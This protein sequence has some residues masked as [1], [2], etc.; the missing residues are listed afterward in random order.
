MKNTV[1][2]NDMRYIA[3]AELPWELLANQSILVTGANG[4]LPAYMIETLLYLNSTRGL[5]VKVIGLVR[6]MLR[7]NL[8]FQK[9]AHRTDF[10]LIEH[11]VSQPFVFESSLN[12]IVHAA[13]QASPKYY[14]SDPVGTLAANVLGTYY[15]LQLAKQHAV[16]DF[17]YFSS[18][19]VY[20]EVDSKH[21]PTIETAYGLVDPLNI[22]S[23]YA[24]SKR[25]AENMLVSFSHQ[26]NIPGKIVRPFHTYGPGL[27]LDDGRVFSDFIAD[28]VYSRD[29]QVL[30]DGRAVR[31]FCYLADAVVG[32]FTVLLKGKNREAYNI[33]NP[34]CAISIL[35]LANR[36]STHFKE[37]NIQ[38]KQVPRLQNNAYTESNISINCPDI[39]KARGLGW[40]PLISIEQGFSQTV[41]SFS[42][43]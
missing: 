14:A 2:D 27:R 12:Y 40:C 23:C 33:G 10:E 18:G 1:F 7:G 29:I 3:A 15:L 9:Y 11:D 39:S 19:E 38:V 41:A 22:R 43:V 6:N 13:S 24:E 25:M 42:E 17:L 28:I 4:F 34:D 30:G 35:E 26:F 37:K 36:L 8:R 32:Y 21:I 5:N 16:S 20:G 31:S